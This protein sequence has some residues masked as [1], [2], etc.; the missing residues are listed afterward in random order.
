MGEKVNQEEEPQQPNP[1]VD[2]S[3]FQEPM[4]S[5]TNS[6]NPNRSPICRNYGNLKSEIEGADAIG[7]E[8]DEKRMKKKGNKQNSVFKS[9]NP[10]MN[11]GECGE[12]RESERM[13]MA[14]RTAEIW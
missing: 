6:S 14:D 4:K 11:G 13:I 8:I 10:A 7:A 5:S 12:E 1:T 3:Q 2:K 9:K